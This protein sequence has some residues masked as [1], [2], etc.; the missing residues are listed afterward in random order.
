MRE[1]KLPE[2]IAAYFEADRRDGAAVARCFTN[3]GVVIDE[4]RTYA[5]ARQ[6]KRGKL[7]LPAASRISQNRSS[8]RKKIAST[9]S[10][11]E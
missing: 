10:R 8:S 2:P 4:G 3:D 7:Q 11:A 5:G 6:S 1:L 9:S